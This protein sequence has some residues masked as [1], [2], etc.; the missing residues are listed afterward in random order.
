MVKLKTVICMQREEHLVSQ[1]PSNGCSPSCVNNLL[2]CTPSE[3]HT[4]AHTLALLIFARALRL[5]QAAS[6]HHVQCTVQWTSSFPWS[7]GSK[8]SHPLSFT[9]SVSV[10]SVNH[11][12][13]KPS[14]LFISSPFFCYVTG[15]F[16][17]P[18]SQRNCLNKETT[19]GRSKRR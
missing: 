4:Q 13:T 15:Q 6:S 5:K 8:D 11:V 3:Q 17:S 9:C 10:L 14:F 7:A 2:M 1:L 16:E 12:L 19:Q 18:S